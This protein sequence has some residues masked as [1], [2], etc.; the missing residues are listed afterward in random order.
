MSGVHVVG[1][2]ASG[3]SIIHGLAGAW[4]G[5]AAGIFGTQALGGLGGVSFASQ[6]VGTLAGCGFALVSGFIVY[7]GLKAFMGIRMSEEEEQ[8]GADLS[9][10]K[11][12]ARPEAGISR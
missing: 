3:R 1:D 9:I 7:G 11:I 5:L 10:H 4:G 2:L 8:A 6:L 12:A